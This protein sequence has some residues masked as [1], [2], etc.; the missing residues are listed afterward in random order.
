MNSKINVTVVIPNYNG[1]KWMEICLKSLDR[2]VFKDFKV[3]IVDNGS[4]DG[5]IQMVEE[6]FPHME[7]RRLDK[8]YGFSYAVNYGIKESDTEY[9]LLL[10]NDTEVDEN[11]VEELYKAI[12]KSDR[13]FS[14]S[15][16]MLGYYDRSVIDDAGDIYSVFGWAAQRGVGT[17]AT[18]Y[19][20]SVNVFSS[21]AG[22]AIYRK[23]AFETVGYFDLLH[24]AYLEDVDLGYRARIHGYRNV[25]CPTAIVYHI[26]SATSGGTVYNDFKVKL[27]S[28][29]NV[30]LNYK[31]MPLLQLII[32]FPTLAIGTFIKYLYFKKFGYGK[33]Y[34]EG[35]KEAFATLDKCNKVKFKLKN[36]LNYVII[37]FELILNAIRYFN[38]YF[39]NKC[40]RVLGK[41]K[42]I[43][44]KNN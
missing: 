18:G 28:R 11:F 16:K 8:N 25:Y 32:N 24:F 20:K 33:P 23:K 30:Y 37:E 5:S 34:V 9:V 44:G 14:C 6:K 40:K 15:S 12:R 31:N 36:T 13:I 7:V 43:L 21:C 41:I 2:Q 42:R 29:N 1:M 17:K 26:G 4:T 38:F 35:I 22:A 27:S 3:M 10:N 39:V 19:N